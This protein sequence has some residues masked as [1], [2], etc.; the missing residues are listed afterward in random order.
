[1]RARRTIGAAAALTAVLAGPT[2]AGATSDYVGTPPTQV[3]G[4]ELVKPVAVA[5]TQEAQDP[6]TLPVTGGDLAGMALF[7]AGAVVLGTA[8]VRRSRPARVVA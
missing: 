5:G 3:Q 7:G 4:I 8:L 2:A 6:A 1:M